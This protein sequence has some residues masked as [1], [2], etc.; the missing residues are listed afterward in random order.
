MSMLEK[1]DS[2]RKFLLLKMAVQMS[3]DFLPYDFFYH[4][5]PY[6]DIEDILALTRVN[7]TLHKKLWIEQYAAQVMKVGMSSFNY[8]HVLIE[9]QVH[10]GYSLEYSTACRKK[11]SF[12]ET[13][14]VFVESS[15]R[16]RKANPSFTTHIAQLEPLESN[17]PRYKLGHGVFCYIRG[18]SDTQT[19]P[20]KTIL[21]HFNIS[22]RTTITR[23]LSD[24]TESQKLYRIKEVLFCSLE[25][26]VL[27]SQGIEKKKIRVFVIRNGQLHRSANLQ[28]LPQQDH[29]AVLL[30]G[31][32]LL[33]CTFNDRQGWNLSVLDLTTC[34]RRGGTRL[35][36]EKC[37]PHNLG[38][39]F[40]FGAFRGNFYILHTQQPSEPLAT[41]PIQPPEIDYSYHS[42]EGLMSRTQGWGRVPGE[43]PVIEE[44]FYMVGSI[45]ITF[46]ADM[47]WG[48]IQ[49]WC[50]NEYIDGT[51]PFNEYTELWLESDPLNGNVLIIESRLEAMSRGKKRVFFQ[52]PVTGNRTKSE[53]ECRNGASYAYV[54]RSTTFLEVLNNRM[55]SLTLRSSTSSC[56]ICQ[57]DIH[58]EYEIAASNSRSL[59]LVGRD[60]SF[61]LVSFDPS[62]APLKCTSI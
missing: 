1:L 22:K 3:F 11:R 32:A 52:Q 10:A 23:D 5:I 53:V 34:R 4:L 25:M 41:E 29:P 13:L 45:P 37:L 36:L 14:F 6:C 58:S 54:P 56:T 30:H 21:C 59:V 18:S 33:V 16:I 17:P 15:N 38:R 48:K 44:D 55:N 19:Q 28:I 43:T 2:T 26:V 47:E 31:D 60:S 8:W 7:K 40:C 62:I 9:Y 20:D 57:G 35:G 39:H 49:R 51:A 27:Y 61:I 12:R 42:R 50:K 24:E 46:V